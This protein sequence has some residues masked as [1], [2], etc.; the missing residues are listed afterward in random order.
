M[1]QA[2]TDWLDQTDELRRRTLEW[3]FD[4]ETVQV[5]SHQSVHVLQT[6]LAQIRLYL[7]SH[8]C[9]PAEFEP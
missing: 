7:P 6:G 2:L 4:I 1:K 5:N 9:F 8:C 3:V